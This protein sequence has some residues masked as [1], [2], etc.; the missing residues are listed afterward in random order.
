M[1]KHSVEINGRGT[2]VNVAPTVWKLLKIW[3]RERGIPIN[4]LVSEINDNRKHKNLSSEIRV[5]VL[6]HL[7]RTALK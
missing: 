2:S 6:E 7:K 5:K 4:Q 1:S 3:A